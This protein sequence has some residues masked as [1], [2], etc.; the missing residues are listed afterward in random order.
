MELKLF[1]ERLSELGIAYTLNECMAAHTTFGVGGAADVLVSPKTEAEAAGVRHTAAECYVPLTVL[2]NGSDLLVSDLGVEGAVMSTAAMKNIYRE[3]GLLVAEAGVGLSSLCLFACKSG[4]SGLEFAYGIPGTVGG[5]VYMN[6]GAYGGEIKDVLCSVTCLDE[7]GRSAVLS[8]EKLCLG[9]RTSVLQSNGYILL[10]AAFSLSGDEPAEIKK[11]MLAFTE[12][13]AAKQPIDKKS[14]GS[15]F[16]RPEG[17]YAGTLIEG[18]GLKGCR[19]GGASVSEK[20]AGFIV[21]DGGASCADIIGLI[22]RVRDKVYNDSG[23][24]LEPEV[25]FIGRP[26]HLPE[27]EKG[28][29]SCPFPLI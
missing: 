18:C 19:V 8:A 10:S 26:M 15:T 22:C 14:A 24:V 25:K 2:G 20:H 16:K 12:K 17:Y 1:T 6:A 27:C 7:S 23:V 5:A 29:T 13:R 3:N 11:R 4:L 28:E 21:N 9:Y